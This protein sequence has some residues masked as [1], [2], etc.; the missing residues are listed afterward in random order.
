MRKAQLDA[1]SRSFADRLM[2]WKPIPPAGTSVDPAAESQRLRQ[3]AALGAAESTG[4]TPIIQR[5]RQG[6]LDSLF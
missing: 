4:D 3:N 5:R 6:I 1:P 2:F